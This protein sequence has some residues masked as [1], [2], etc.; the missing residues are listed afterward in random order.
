M[1]AMAKKIAIAL[2]ALGVLLVPAS[3]AGATATPAW[4]FA[5]SSVP[6]NFEPGSTGDAYS[7]LAT[8]IGA[9]PTK[10]PITITDTLPAG[11]TLEASYVIEGDASSAGS[12]TK[13]GNTATCIIPG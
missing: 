10:G 1:N 8:H 11:L 7:L 9:V 6:T 4:R 13:D 3:Q 12:C 2:M 5:V